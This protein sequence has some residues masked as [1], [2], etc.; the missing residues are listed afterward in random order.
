MVGQLLFQTA[1][2]VAEVLVLG[3]G[4]V[5]VT[6]TR[7]LKAGGGMPGTGEPLSRVTLASSH[8]ERGWRRRATSAPRSANALRGA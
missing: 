4:P 3:G 5:G 8:G 6:E 2:Q 1:F 7:A